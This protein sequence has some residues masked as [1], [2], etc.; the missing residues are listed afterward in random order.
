MADRSINMLP[1]LLV[2]V[3]VGSSENGNGQIV[4]R[5]RR[6]RTAMATAKKAAMVKLLATAMPKQ[7]RP[8]RARFAVGCFR[9]R[10]I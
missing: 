1:F 10:F 5:E 2:L 7:V 4:R 9:I 3:P 6:A 8:K